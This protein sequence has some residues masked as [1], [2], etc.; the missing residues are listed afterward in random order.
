MDFLPVGGDA[1]CGGVAD[2]RDGSAASGGAAR[3]ASCSLM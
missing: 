2:A 1:H 3:S